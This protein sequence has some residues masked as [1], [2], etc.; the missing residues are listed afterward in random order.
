MRR[1]KTYSN[2]KSEIIYSSCSD[3]IWWLLTAK[4]TKRKG[5]GYFPEDFRE[6]GAYFPEVFW[7]IGAYFPEVVKMAM[8]QKAICVNQAKGG[9]DTKQ[10]ELLSIALSKAW[11]LYNGAIF[12]DN[13]PEYILRYIYIKI[14]CKTPKISKH[15]TYHPTRNPTTFPSSMYCILLYFNKHII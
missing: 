15:T 4:I 9:A 5:W 8:L 1:K 12:T 10:Q 7:E 6:I 13:L 14:T 2:I 3:L 11:A